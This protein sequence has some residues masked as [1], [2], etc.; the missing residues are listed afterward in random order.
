MDTLT[1]S[2]NLIEQ[3]IKARNNR[4]YPLALDIFDKAEAYPELLTQAYFEQAVTY[5]VLRN[6][7]CAKKL[8]YLLL[9]LDPKATNPLVF[10]ADL[11]IDEANYDE[12]E[13]LI[14]KAIHDDPTYTYALSAMVRLYEEKG[15]YEAEYNFFREVIPQFNNDLELLYNFSF[16]LISCPAYRNDKLLTEA[17]ENLYRVQKKG[18]EDDSL[19][20]HIGKAYLLLKEN[21]KCVEHLKLFLDNRRAKNPAVGIYGI[22]LFIEDFEREFFENKLSLLEEHGDKIFI[23]SVDESKHKLRDLM[24]GEILGH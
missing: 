21:E 22:T 13:R 5:S 24:R 6:Y 17:L 10:L 14:R 16:F 18:L 15:D 7:T 3:G 12:A 1:V 9:E 8:L 2:E 11:L 4:D 19:E 20:Y 23:Q